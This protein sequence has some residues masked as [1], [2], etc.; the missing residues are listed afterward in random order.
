MARAREAFAGVRSATPSGGEP[1]SDL[2]C[3]AYGRSCSILRDDALAALVESDQHLQT[4]T[5]DKDVTV[6]RYDVR[7]LLHD[8]RQLGNANKHTTG[9]SGTE[10]E[11]ELDFERF[12]GLYPAQAAVAAPEA[13]SQPDAGFAPGMAAHLTSL[14]KVCSSG[15][16][17]AQTGLCA[18]AHH[19]AAVSHGEPEQY[20]AV[21][22]DYSSTEAVAPVEQ[23]V[24]APMAPVI[25]DVPFVA[26]FAVPDSM[27]G[28]LPS[29]ERMH[30]V[31]YVTK[32][33]VF[34]NQFLVW[35]LSPSHLESCAR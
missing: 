35:K 4:W 32:S 5:G 23:A 24:A 29:T 15:T 20:S 3:C 27:K 33:C 26:Q 14:P 25:P 6:D 30:K 7:L 8:A 12:R 9:I 17:Q 16:L 28:H 11:K 18:G 21:A 22:F 1:Q 13:E 34:R 10:D 31:S 2:T 19:T